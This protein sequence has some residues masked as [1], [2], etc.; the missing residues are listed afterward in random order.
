MYWEIGLL[1]MSI[2]VLLFVLF[3]IPTLIQIRKTAR[4][5]ER[6][7]EAVNRELP[8][9]LQDLHALTT[10]THEVTLAVKTQVEEKVSKTVQ[11][12]FKILESLTRSVGHVFQRV[13]DGIESLSSGME[14]LRGGLPGIEARA[15]AGIQAKLATGLRAFAVVVGAL[16]N[17]L[18]GMQSRR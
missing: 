9:I 13:H 18:E 14:P 3:T 5:V 6:T 16:R 4:S 7:F 15:Y 12:N 8:A 10:L 1:L 11:L 17:A 2:A